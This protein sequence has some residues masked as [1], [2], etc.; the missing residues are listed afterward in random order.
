MSLSDSKHIA[1]GVLLSVV[2]LFVVGSAQAEDWVTYRHDNNRSAATNE[3][4]S[5]P[6]KSAWTYKSPRAPKMAW[7]GPDRRLFEGQELRQRVA[8]DD[9]LHV[10][11][12]GDRAYFGSSVD[13]QLHCVDA[14]SGKEIW[15][16]FSGGAVRLAPT[17]S[18]GRVLFGSDD[19]YVY[20]LAVADGKLEWKLR[21]G[22][23]EDWLLARGELISRWPV[24]TGVLVE[25]GIAY[26]GAGIFPHENVL[27][28]AVNVSDG[29]IVWKKDNISENDAGR[30][31]LSP[32]GYLL[33]N[34]EML[35]VPSGRSLPAAVNLK[36]GDRVYKRVFGW[37][38]EGGGQIG[39]TQAL[40]S[41]GQLFAGG[42]HHM[43]A[44]DQKTGDIGFGWF[45]GRQMSVLG[46][47]AYVANGAEVFRINRMEYAVASRERQKLF[48]QVRELY[49]KAYYRS[50]KDGAV[51]TVAT[52][53]ELAK[54]KS[55]MTALEQKGRK[56]TAK[57]DL[58][59]SLI[60][61]GNLAFVGGPK[62]VAAFE[63]ETGKEVWTAPV[64]GDARG[65]VV[66]NGHLYVSTTSGDIAVFAPQ[67]AAVPATPT[68]SIAAS[69]YPNDEWSPVYA[70]AADEILAK[71][72]IKKG[73]CL[74]V[75]G[76]QG[77]LAYELAARS[78]LSIYAVEPD[79]EKVAAARKALSSAHLYGN[80]VTFYQGDLADIPYA[81]YF[82]NLI[83][84]DTQ[85]RTGT[86]VG[87]PREIVRH[88]K[89]IGGT[90]CLGHPA[91]SPNKTLALDDLRNW[92]KATALDDAG[93][94]EDHETWVALK[95]GALPGAGSWTHLYGG[96]GN[97]ASSEDQR[98]KGGL[99][100]L[101]YGDPGPGKM[102]NRHDGA[103]GPL[104]VHGR[105]YV[106]GQTSVM[107]YDAYNGL[108]LW[109]RG[110]EGAIRTG[111]FQ[112]F[113]PGNVVASEDSL[114]VMV[115]D[116]C[117]ELDGAT[118]VTKATYRLP[119][120]KHDSQYQ[121]GYLAYSDGILFG[122][123]SVRKEVAE[124][125]RRRGRVTEDSTDA[126]FAVE[127]GTGKHLWT[128]EGKNISHHTIA[129]GPGRVYFV[130]STISNEK[131]AA[132]LNQDKTEL[133][134]LSEGEAKKVEA[135]MKEQDERLTVAL[136]ARTGKQ[137]WAKSVDVTDCSEIGTGGGQLTLIFQNN[138]LL[139]CGANANGHYWKQFVEGE[140]KHRRLVALS[141]DD[142]HKL[143]AKD[144][145]YRHRPIVIEDQIIA[146]PW[147]Y[148]LYTGAQKMREHPLTGESVP[149]SMVR[150]G[151]H[152]GMLTGC[153]SMLMFRS[154]FTAFYNLE[155]DSGT[156]HFAGHRIGCW[157]NAIPANG[158]VMIPESGAGCVC[159]F[160]IE[161]TVTMEPRSERRPWT[162]YSSVGAKT[163][164][165]HMALNLGAPGDR[166]DAR[167][168]VW[169]S[170]PRPTTSKE[171]SLDLKLD[172]VPE[173]LK[174][175]GFA[176]VNSNANP[177]EG[178]ETPWLFTS[179]ARGLTRCKLPLLGEKQAPADSF[180][181]SGIRS[182]EFT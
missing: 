108:F 75:G 31:D 141:A 38:N 74:V 56:W 178:A 148:D 65:L 22:P 36:T 174:D 106:Q 164:V 90:I 121:W 33:A 55:E 165:S 52:V 177:V 81:N 101:W 134:K 21:A 82:A 107:A 59:S 66:A 146:E 137:V 130:D 88:L 180:Q 77:R 122:T 124:R 91:N 13:H 166:K 138:V 153:P 131:R 159:L 133:K 114:F 105:L 139:L 145:N 173:F 147:G 53:A 125:Q 58:E 113:N 61:A 8:F 16:F 80:R 51:D 68:P 45:T 144:A 132:L 26:F 98:V 18:A 37:R 40:L 116:E 1:C 7:S 89:P 119:D 94:I 60:V 170:Y 86:L 54:I 39:G 128:Y 73:F 168:K 6:L 72:G 30:D 143:W 35:F 150:P 111:V 64:E 79:A 47:A 12:V 76:E 179:S 43:V 118:G 19:G 11:V 136:D 112:N 110:D 85:L 149:W 104:S 158:L 152:C 151:H 57:S 93:K 5:V 42:P 95:R 70:A 142:G 71:T 15:T 97:T 46:D 44:L 127:V 92:L 126:I 100:V 169:L 50:G 99:G 162:I 176:S 24:R 115:K 62:R 103:A 25:D 171:T 69:P 172:I 163:P 140:F 135:K 154:G 123:A 175:G 120:K 4:L 34:K 63:I 96:P 49:I 27:L 28:Y 67:D 161:S 160:S 48:P 182:L 129:L 167:G 78:E 109:E 32:Q 156:E 2:G 181:H 157:V 87:N 83:V 41:D 155:D 10:S 102:V 20:C 14:P 23:S 3:S 84:S 9:A 29:K 117:I 17:I